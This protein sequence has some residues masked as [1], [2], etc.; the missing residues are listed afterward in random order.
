MQPTFLFVLILLAKH[1]KV[2]NPAAFKLFPKASPLAK[3]SAILIPLK[4]PGPLVENK[5]SISCKLFLETFNAFCILIKSKLALFFST[6]IFS[7]KTI[8]LLLAMII[9]KSFKERS[10]T[11]N[12]NYSINNL[13]N[14]IKHIYYSKNYLELIYESYRDNH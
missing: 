12:F 10:K 1:S 9:V 6:L 5:K 8:D 13:L 14:K 4:F 2:D 7:L 11:I 3:E